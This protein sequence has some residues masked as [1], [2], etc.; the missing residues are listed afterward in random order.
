MI[1]GGAVVMIFA[2]NSSTAKAAKHLEWLVMQLGLPLMGLSVN[3]WLT[4]GGSVSKWSH[5]TVY[6]DWHQYDD[7]YRERR[8]LLLAGSMGF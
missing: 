4:L 2:Q 1:L 5:V 6:S 7:L 8:L 3:L